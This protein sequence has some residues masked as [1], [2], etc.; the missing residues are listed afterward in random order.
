[1][2]E[3]LPKRDPEHKRTKVVKIEMPKNAKYPHPIN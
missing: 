2:P 3:D 1:M